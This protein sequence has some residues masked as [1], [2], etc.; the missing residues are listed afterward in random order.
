MRP[1]ILTIFNVFFLL[2]LQLSFFEKKT[3][4]PTRIPDVLE[5]LC[6]DPDP[7][8]RE[9]QVGF[10]AFFA[11]SCITVSIDARLVLTALG[12]YSGFAQVR[13]LLP[14][15]HTRG[16]VILAIK[17]FGD[18][19]RFLLDR[20]YVAPTLPVHAGRAAAP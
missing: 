17:E 10:Y 3:F 18:F 2:I 15:W 13:V 4:I 8:T 11:L 1:G 12:F 7:K 20:R 6:G 5:R 9:I 14:T 16:G 19:W